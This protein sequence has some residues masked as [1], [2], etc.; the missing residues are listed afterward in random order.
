MKLLLKQHSQLHS[1]MFLNLQQYIN[2][3]IKRL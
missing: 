3:T 2:I 1:G